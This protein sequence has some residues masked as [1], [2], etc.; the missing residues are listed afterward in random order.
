VIW[1]DPTGNAFI[2]V[3]INPDRG[4]NAD[5]TNDQMSSQLASFIKRVFGDLN[6]FSM[7]KSVIQRDNSIRITWSYAD[8]TNGRVILVG[9]SFIGQDDS[10]TGIFTI[11]VP[12]D[13]FNSLQKSLNQIINSFK[14]Q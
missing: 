2:H 12:N 8:E 7:E 1:T 3:N 4:N 14:G 11:V 10:K 9:N 13:Q 5:I 6:E